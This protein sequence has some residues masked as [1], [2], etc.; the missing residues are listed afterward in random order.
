MRAKTGSPFEKNTRASNTKEKYKAYK[1]LRRA[2]PDE[3]VPELIDHLLG[4][5]GGKLQINNCVGSFLD[6][7][8]SS[9]SEIHLSRHIVKDKV[10]SI[11]NRIK[12]KWLVRDEI[13][14]KYNIDAVAYTEDTP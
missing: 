3:L 9:D 2:F 6:S 5:I 7:M 14:K 13:L 1:R 4:P 11:A 12:K 8:R 10:F